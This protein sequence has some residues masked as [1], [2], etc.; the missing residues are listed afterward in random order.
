MTINIADNSPRISYSVSQG[1]TTTSFAV[2]F[3]F[4][5]D[6]DLNVYIDGTKKT[7]TT[8][9]SVSGGDGSTGTVAMS[10]TGATGGSTVVIT[11]DIALERTTDFPTS[12]AFNIVSLNTELD[13]FVAIAA[14]LDDKANRSLQLTDFDAAAS[15]VLPDVDGRKGK[16]L[17]FNSSSGAVEA[18]PSIGDVQTVSAASA[19]IQILAHLQD[20]TTT[21]NGLSGLAAIASAISTVNGISSN[22]S[23][24]AGI[25]SNITTVAGISANVSTVAGK[26]SEVTSVAAKASLLTSDFISDLN[27]LTSDVIADL[28]TLATSSIVSDLDTLSASGVLTNIA[29]LSASAVVADMAILGTTAVA[30]DMAILGT[31]D[32]VADMAILAT[33]DVVADMNTLGTSDIVSDMNVLGTSANVTAMNT[34]GTS[35]NVTAMSNVSGSIA[36]VNTVA[37][38]I[39]GVNSFADRYRVASSDPSSSLNEGDLA[40]NSSSNVLKYYNGSAWVSLSAGIANLVA[41]GSPQLGANLDMNGQDIVT[42]SNADLDL[43]PNGTGRVVVRGNTNQGSIVLNCENNSHGITIQSAPHSAGATYTVKLPNALGTS[44]S[45][46]IVTSD[47]SGNIK[48][49]EEIQAK[50]YLETVVAL[51]AA[52]SVTLDL[53]TANVFT[54]TT[55]Q[56]TTFVFD[57]SNIQLTTNDAFAFTLRVLAGGAHNLVWPSSVKWAGGAAPDAPAS[58]EY[59]TYVFYTID[60]GVRWDGAQAVDAGA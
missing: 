14:D 39:A 2:P 7:I 32:V 28:N 53:S 12:G 49:A 18:G 20:G 30:A 35:A 5:N 26:A 29:T 40:Y 48:L 9:Y 1:A 21:S 44:S 43:A 4:F 37:S 16:T 50:A 10:V 47:A 33:N 36:N 13:R 60:G 51:S 57:Y 52:S 15:L 46:A 55:G 19:D 34:L 54:L 56:N 11:R 42:T 3:E 8:H 59:N 6:A 17:A 58:G 27:T 25:S 38:N 41:D 31:A 24:V 45:S 22:V 23:T